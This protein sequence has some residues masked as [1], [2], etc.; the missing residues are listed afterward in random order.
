MR[1][2]Y[3]GNDRPKKLVT[4]DSGGNVL[5]GFAYTLDAVGNRTA[6]KQSIGG[7]VNT[8]RYRFD[9]AYRLVR[10]VRKNVTGGNALR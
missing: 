4:K 6:I 10:E 5:A 8:I 7:T 2:R 1:Y 9:P 3:D